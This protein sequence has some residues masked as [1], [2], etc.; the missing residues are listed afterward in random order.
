MQSYSLTVAFPVFSYNMRAKNLKK[1]NASGPTNGCISGLKDH[2]LI[3]GPFHIYN[4]TETGTKLNRSIIDIP[5]TYELNP[6][7]KS[8]NAAT[9]WHRP[10]NSTDFLIL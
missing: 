7:T 8:E 5:F 10:G 9:I 1:S 2:G 6:R 4:R 3:S